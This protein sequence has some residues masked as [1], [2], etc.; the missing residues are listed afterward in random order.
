[1]TD[2]E[3]RR[4]LV[5]H[6][7]TNASPTVGEGFA[8]VDVSEVAK[9]SGLDPETFWS[10]HVLFLEEKGLVEVDVGLPNHARLTSLGYNLLLD[11]KIDGHLGDGTSRI[12]PTTSGDSSI[13]RSR[14][15][16]VVHGHDGEARE[17]VARC[18]EKLDLEPIIL[19]EMP[20]KG[21]T[22]IEKFENHSDVPF[23]VVLLTPDDMGYARDINPE[24]AK[25]RCRQN[26]MLELGYFI[27]KLGRDKVCALR[28]EGVEI[29]SD[30][31]GVLFTDLDS[32]G[33]WRLKL[34]KEIK[35]AGIGVDLNRAC[36]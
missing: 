30:Y 11:G 15:I 7:D 13:Q 19:H 25:P 5:D 29:P 18:L 6:L 24:E 16:F 20:D 10:R 12:E 36:S 34:A 33:G 23:A 14:K 3:I 8:F 27:G 22:I 21:R 1:M 32:T 17:T 28:K 31:Q 2:S 4:Q 26:V 35:D 9:L